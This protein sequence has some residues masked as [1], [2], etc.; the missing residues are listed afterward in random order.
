MGAL[1]LVLRTSGDFFK[2]FLAFFKMP[3]IIFKKVLVVVWGAF[4]LGALRGLATV[5]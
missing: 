2:Q 3:L 4:G 1:V 5:R